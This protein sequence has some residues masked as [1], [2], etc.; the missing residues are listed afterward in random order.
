MR[1]VRSK[2]EVA[3]ER[4]AQQRAATDDPLITRVEACA[5]LGVGRSTFYVG[6]LDG[7]FPRPIYLGPRCPRWRRSEVHAAI[8]A[9]PRTWQEAAAQ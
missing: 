5:M 1:L 6:V 7:R 3:A 9:A 4:R 2:G 8:A